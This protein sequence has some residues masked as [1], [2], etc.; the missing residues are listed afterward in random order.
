MSKEKVF[1]RI[2]KEMQKNNIWDKTAHFACYGDSIMTYHVN[3]D[4]VLAEISVI[5]LDT[6]FPE[7]DIEDLIDEFYTEFIG[8]TFYSTDEEGNTEKRI[9]EPITYNPHADKSN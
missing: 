8:V 2:K 5:S 7:E 6:L 1:A 3:G 4:N 9:G